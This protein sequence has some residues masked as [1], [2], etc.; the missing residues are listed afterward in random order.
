VEH[1]EFTGFD[2]M[3]EGNGAII[4]RTM[5]VARRIFAEWAPGT[6]WISLVPVP[7]EIRENPD[8]TSLSKH[9]VRRSESATVEAEAKI[10]QMSS[11]SWIRIDRRSRAG[12]RDLEGVLFVRF[13]GADAVMIIGAGALDP[14]KKWPERLANEVVPAMERI[15]ASIRVEREGS[16]TSGTKNRPNQALQTTPMARSVYEKTI[17]FGHPQRGV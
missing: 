7:E 5:W 6:G 14:D 3:G 1:S 11:G 8:H 16:E 17:E 10:L 15:A 4:F 12:K 2:E 9:F 13:V